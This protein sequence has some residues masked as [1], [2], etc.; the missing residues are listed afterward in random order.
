MIVQGEDKPLESD[1]S[2]ERRKVSRS[3]L[4]CGVSAVLI[5]LF[6]F[7]FGMHALTYDTVSNE[8]VALF[9]MSGFAGLLAVLSF[10]KGSGISE[11]DTVKGFRKK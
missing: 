5:G 7:G 10:A 11:K 1:N 3:G 6:T 8:T 2:F 4:A 9:L